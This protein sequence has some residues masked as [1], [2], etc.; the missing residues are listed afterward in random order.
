MAKRMHRISTEY[1]IYIVF[2]FAFVC[3]FLAWFCVTNVIRAMCE[4]NRKRANTYSIFTFRRSPLA[5]EC[6]SACTSDGRYPEGLKT[7][8]IRFRKRVRCTQGIRIFVCARRVFGA[9]WV[10]AEPTRIAACRE[11]STHA[12]T[13]RRMRLCVPRNESRA[14]SPKRWPNANTLNLK[15]NIIPD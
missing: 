7:E 5:G 3:S 2:R 12:H 1:E 14:R 10:D 15:I 8:V 4:W 11:W 6:V 9:G 13:H